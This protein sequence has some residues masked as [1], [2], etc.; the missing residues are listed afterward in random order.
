MW[1][2]P[3][4]FLPFARRSYSTRS[5]TDC[6]DW[7][8]RPFHN[9]IS[10]FSWGIRPLAAILVVYVLRKLVTMQLL[11]TVSLHR[12]MWFD[13]MLLLSALLLFCSRLV[14]VYKRHITKPYFTV[15]TLSGFLLSSSFSALSSSSP[16]LPTCETAKR[17][18]GFFC[19][20]RNL[21]ININRILV[22]YLKIPKLRGSLNSFAF[23]MRIKMYYL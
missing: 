12:K 21:R 9:H 1:S 8:L 17:L 18:Y 20:S 2:R 13:F 23:N 6:V 11:T 16:G 14:H 22:R 19:I 3:S 5:L 4:R 10:V 7:N 15:F